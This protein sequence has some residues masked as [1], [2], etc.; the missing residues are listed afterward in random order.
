M[1]ISERVNHRV[2][3]IYR[4][5]NIQHFFH[6][7]SYTLRRAVSHN[8]TK[9]ICTRTD[10][11]PFQ[12]HINRDLKIRGRRRQRKRRWK[13]EF[14]FFQS[15]SRLL[16]SLTLSNPPKVEF[17]RTISKFRY[18]GEISSLLVYF[19]CKT[20][21]QA[22]SRRSRAVTAKKCTKKRDARAKLLFWL[23]NLLLFW[24]PRCRGRRRILMSLLCFSVGPGTALGIKEEEKSFP[25]LVHRWAR[26]ARRFFLLFH[27]IYCLFS[28]LRL[29]SLVP[30][31][32]TAVY[33]ITCHWKQNFIGIVK[34]FI[35]DR[36][37]E[38]LLE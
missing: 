38:D 10:E 32:E 17:L 16:K 15:S 4:K 20:W 28:P 19:L 31:W 25:S 29:R 35:Y 33:Q 13:S 21:N 36:I 22:F 2:T 11:F 30:G 9:R 7:D 26:F 24:Q 18:R 34:R 27:P 23:L 5:K 6:T 8:K 3:N 1:R 14:A 37:R 12:H